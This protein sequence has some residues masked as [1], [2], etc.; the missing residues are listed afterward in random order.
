MLLCLKEKMNTLIKKQEKFLGLLDDVVV[1]TRL[2]LMCD[3]ARV[4]NFCIIIIII[5]RYPR[6]Y[7]P[8]TDRQQLSD[9]AAMVVQH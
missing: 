1:Y 3:Y 2:R 5:P 6:R 9:K 4:I 8:A 7:S